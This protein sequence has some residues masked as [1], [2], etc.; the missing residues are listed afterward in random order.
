MGKAKQV[1]TPAMGFSSIRPL[2]CP[3]ALPHLFPPDHFQI[4]KVFRALAWILGGR[5]T[6]LRSVVLQVP[7]L[8]LPTHPLAS[9][10][11]QP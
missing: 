3:H 9:A 4:L 11:P 6:L 2:P 1:G 5:A 10:R 7:S 8:P